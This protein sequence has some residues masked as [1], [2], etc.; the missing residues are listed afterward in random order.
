[1]TWQKCPICYGTGIDKCIEGY[2]NTVTCN[3]CNGKRIIDTLTG[4]PPG[5]DILNKCVCT[6]TSSRN[7]P[8]HDKGEL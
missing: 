8:V 3:L 2:T 5:E 1:M 7:C 4:E 6:E